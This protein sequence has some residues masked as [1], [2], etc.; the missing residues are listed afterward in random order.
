MMRGLRVSD[1]FGGREALGAAKAPPAIEIPVTSRWSPSGQAPSGV[2]AALNAPSLERY[3]MVATIGIGIG[4]A[5]AQVA[6][7]TPF[8]FDAGAYWAATPGNLYTTGWVAQG[9]YGSFIYS[10]AFADAIAPFRLLPDRVFTGLWQLGLF[11]V[12][13]MVLRGWSLPIVAAGLVSLVAP[14]PL[15]GFVLSDLAHGNV[16]VLLGAIAVLGIRYPALWSFALLSKVTPGIGLLWFVARREWRNLAIALAVTGAI[17]LVSFLYA[18]GD[19]FDW[20]AFLIA[21][22]DHEFPLWVV[23][24]SLPVRLAMSAVLIIWG[25]RTDRPWVLP[26]AVGWAIPMPYPTMLA[27]MVFALCYVRFPSWRGGPVRG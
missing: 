10:P 9:Q 27:T 22:T 25:A 21:S 15:V 13:A 19:W 20:A 26:I 16:Q 8:A 23:P 17:T 14:I 1:L 3:F 18:P 12:L 6:H 7:L 11:V 5:V 4:F 24:I 2:S